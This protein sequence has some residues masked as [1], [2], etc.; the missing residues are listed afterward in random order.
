[1]WFQWISVNFHRCYLKEKTSFASLM[2]WSIISSA[3]LTILLSNP[4]VRVQVFLFKCCPPAKPTCQ[5]NKH[6][7]LPRSS[8]GQFIPCWPIGFLRLNTSVLEEKMHVNVKLFLIIL[9]SY[10]ETQPHLSALNRNLHEPT[11]RFHS[12]SSRTFSLLA[13]WPDFKVPVRGFTKQSSD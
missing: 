10:S 8:P 7:F 13:P 6:L 4:K 11:H 1:M 12:F 9:S 2:W 3:L 5:W